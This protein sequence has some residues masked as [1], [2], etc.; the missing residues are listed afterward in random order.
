MDEEIELSGADLASLDKELEVSG[1]SVSLPSD[2]HNSS[3]PRTPKAPMHTD[4][5]YKDEHTM[6]GGDDYGQM[7]TLCSDDDEGE[8]NNNY[9]DGDGAERGRQEDKRGQSF[10]EGNQERE[11]EG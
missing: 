7:L 9:D 8:E 11:D 10:D 6:H 1:T 2:E 4:G 3:S 5:F